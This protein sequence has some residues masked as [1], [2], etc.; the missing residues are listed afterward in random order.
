MTLPRLIVCFDQ[1]TIEH[2]GNTLTVAQGRLDIRQSIEQSM[3]QVCC[4]STHCPVVIDAIERL[5]VAMQEA[6]E[7]LER[8]DRERSAEDAKQ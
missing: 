4:G 2:K 8:R 7:D 3:R 6:Q 1:K 5:F